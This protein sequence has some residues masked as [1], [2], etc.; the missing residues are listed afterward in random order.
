MK[1]D[2]QQKHK[3]ESIIGK[4]I[5]G[6]LMFL[7]LIAIG[8]TLL[9]T[10]FNDNAY[11]SYA[12]TYKFIETTQATEY[13]A[14]TI[15]F[16]QESIN[17]NTSGNVVLGYNNLTSLNYKA[18]NNEYQFDS[19]NFNYNYYSI[20]MQAGSAWLRIYGSNTIINHDPAAQDESTAEIILLYNKQWASFGINAELKIQTNDNTRTNTYT[21]QRITVQMYI[22]KWYVDTT[23]SA[24]FY[25]SISRIEQAPFF[26]WA[27][28]S[29]LYTTMHDFTSAFNM[30]NTFIP[31][32]LSYWLIISLIYFL[33]D[34]VL[35]LVIVLHNRIHN[36]QDT[37]S[38]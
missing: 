4:I 34:I 1:K 31:T 18:N 11:E 6:F 16:T 27:K 21:T 2:K 17:F 30:T 37:L 25:A 13:T 14:N 15:Y 3:G 19:D 24:V 23:I 32:I 8:S 7:P 33:Y 35:T 36:L 38:E 29:I 9:Y 20:N 28:N 26:N 12:G 5:Y 10:T 22:D